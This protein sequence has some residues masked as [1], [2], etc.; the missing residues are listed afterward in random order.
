[1]IVVDDGSTDET[2]SIA[3]GFDGVHLVRHAHKGG[4]AAACNTGLALARGE[5]W[6]LFDADDVMPP[7]RLSCGVAHLQ[8]HPSVGLV[9]GLTEAFVTPGHP[10]PAHWNPAWE[11]GPFPACAG[12][13]LARREVLDCVGPYDERLAVSEDTEWLARAKDAGVRAGRVDAVWLRR[14]IHDG[15][16][17]SNHARNHAVLLRVLRES[18]HRRREARVVD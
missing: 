14:R 13:M 4:V 2:A 12:T 16:N 6:T 18:V 15:S 10:R 8:T 11:A 17:S 1:L 3:A 7:E 5:Y 9:L